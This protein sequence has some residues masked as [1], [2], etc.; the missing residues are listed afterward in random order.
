MIEKYLDAFPYMN[1]YFPI[2]SEKAFFLK[3]LDNQKKL[4]MLDLKQSSN[5]EDSVEICD[6]DFSK[7]IYQPLRFD[8]RKNILYLYSDDDNKENYNIYSLNLTTRAFDQVTD[9][10]YC[11]VLDFSDDLSMLCY[12]DRYKTADG[13]FYT[14]LMIRDME[15]K[16]ENIIA[17]DA[18]WEYRMSWSG[19]LF[20]Q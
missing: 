18:D 3:L 16:E 19:V 6:Q 12:G 10:N 15:T 13:I 9:A 5:Y 17:D 8:Q 14:K 11:G 7:R 1:S 2:D 4:C 20:D